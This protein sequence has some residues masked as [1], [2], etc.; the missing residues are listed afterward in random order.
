MKSELNKSKSRWAEL[1]ELD[2][3][4]SRGTV[5][6]IFAIVAFWVVIATGAGIAIILWL[7]R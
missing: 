7:M 4:E 6:K 5:S 3:D 1:V 2:P